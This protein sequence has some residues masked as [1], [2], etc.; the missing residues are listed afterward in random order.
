MNRLGIALL[1]ALG[2]L[3]TAAAARQE[4]EIFIRGTGARVDYPVG[5]LF[6]IEAESESQIRTFQLE[7]GLT[8]RDCTPDLNIVT[9]KDFSPAGHVDPTQTWTV[10]V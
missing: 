5:I 2:L 4:A 1:S 8:G 3:F 9:P 10:A 6:R 7:F